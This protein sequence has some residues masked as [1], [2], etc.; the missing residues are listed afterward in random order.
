VAS[1]DRSP[2][3]AAAEAGREKEGGE[4]AEEA[5]HSPLPLLLWLLSPLLEEE[6]AVMRW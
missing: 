5:P 3:A 4:E 1:A 6:E 2:A